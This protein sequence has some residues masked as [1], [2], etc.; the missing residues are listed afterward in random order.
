MITTFKTSKDGHSTY[1]YDDKEEFAWISDDRFLKCPFCGELPLIIITDDEGNVK[2]NWNYKPAE[3]LKY[4]KK[5][6]SGLYY[7]LIHP[8]S[9]CIIGEKDWNDIMSGYYH[10]RNAYASTIKEL[11]DEWNS[12][13]N[14]QKEQP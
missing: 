10:F 4:E 12:S 1:H 8:S 2:T 6:W 7:Q 3:I 5:P 14:K 13:I 11:V 9:E